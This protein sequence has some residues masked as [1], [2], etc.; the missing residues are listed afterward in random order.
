LGEHCNYK[1]CTPFKGNFHCPCYSSYPWSH[2]ILTHQPGMTCLAMPRLLSWV[3]TTQLGTAA[4]LTP[5]TMLHLP[6]HLIL[7]PQP[8][9]DHLQIH[10]TLHQFIMGPMANKPFHTLFLTCSMACQSSPTIFTLTNLWDILR[11]CL[12][13]CRTLN[14]P[15]SI[16]HTLHLPLLLPIR[17]N[18][19]Q[20]LMV[21]GHARNTKKPQRCCLSL[22]IYLDQLPHLTVV[23][24]RLLF[25]CLHLQIHLQHFLMNQFLFLRH[26]VSLDYNS[27]TGVY[28]EFCLISK[29]I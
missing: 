13:H 18:A 11:H 9:E 24:A 19:L 6:V 10:R 7:T 4:H 25:R 16:P 5:S 28:S 27:P 20:Q 23:L 17:R 2:H 29:A 12:H 21:W 1:V 26:P 22:W 3:L 15:S 14:Q 8:L